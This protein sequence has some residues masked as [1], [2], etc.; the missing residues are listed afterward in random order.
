MTEPQKPADQRPDDDDDDSHLPNT[1]RVPRWVKREP[2]ADAPLP[3][4]DPEYD[5]R[6]D[7]E[8]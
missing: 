6:S 1:M 5:P 8:L 7:D 4:K 3:P 2:P